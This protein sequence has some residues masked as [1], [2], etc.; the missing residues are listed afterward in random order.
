[1]LQ[2]I[3]DLGPI[4]R[5][6]LAKEV[7]LSNKTVNDVTE[8]LLNEGFIRDYDTIEEDRTRPRGPVPRLFTFCADI[9]Y[10]LGIDVGADKIV[11]LVADMAGQVVG[12]ARRQTSGTKPA[13]ILGEVRL[14][15]ASALRKS[16]VSRASLKAV[17][18]GTPGVVDS[19][20]VR[21]APQLVGWE[22]INLSNELDPSLPCPVLVKNEVHLSVLAERWQ[23]AARGIDDALYIQLGVGVGA[24]LLIK[25]E[26]YG[27][28]TGAAGEIGYM[29]IFPES[30]VT[31]N[32]PGPFEAAVGGNAH[33]RLG[34]KVAATEDG[35]LLRKLAGG[36]PTAVD[37]EVVFA[38]VRQGDPAARRIVETLTSTLARG[39]ATAAVLLDPAVIII[40]GGLSRAGEF[41][42]E[43]LNR[44]LGEILPSPPR[45]VLSSLGSEA[46]AL[47][48]VRLA[49]EFAERQLFEFASADGNSAGK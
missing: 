49:C 20:L 25:G 32:D 10:V 40:G 45:L 27:G 31:Q 38:A 17:A 30:R 22:G 28:A 41:L 15:M 16:H 21:L 18:V 2:T 36:D 9:G 34:A 37:A 29:P 14:A 13:E 12:T 11:A 47:G 7:G 33:A 1:V 23:G 3:R 44:H 46:V 43:P 48:A 39:I 5:T 35:A 8:F 42:I 4:S 26:A 6:H 24:A 19:G